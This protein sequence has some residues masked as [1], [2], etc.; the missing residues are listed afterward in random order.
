MKRAKEA[1]EKKKREREEK[2]ARQ[3]IIC[4][5]NAG[6]EMFKVVATFVI[7]IV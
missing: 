7:K 1:E 3:N 4:D 5:L 2:A 6:F